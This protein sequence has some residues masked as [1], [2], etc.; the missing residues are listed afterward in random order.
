MDDNNIDKLNI[1]DLPESNKT[2]T[3]SLDKTRKVSV[4]AVKTEPEEMIEIE[5]E[6]LLETT[7][8]PTEFEDIF[9][10]EEKVEEEII[11]TEGIVTVEEV[12]ATQREKINENFH[13]ETEIIPNAIEDIPRRKKNKLAIIAGVICGAIILSAIAVAIIILI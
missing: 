8:A 12:F 10:D 1:D 3:F 13:N 6:E 11:N 5:E 2:M 4:N 9:S 7:Q